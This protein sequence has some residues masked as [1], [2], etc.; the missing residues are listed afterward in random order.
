[1]IV[2]QA[3]R[4]LQDQ[5]KVKYAQKFKPNWQEDDQFKKWMKPGK[6]VHHAFCRVCNKQISV[7]ATGRLALVRHQDRD[8]H[9]KLSKSTKAQPS[10]TDMTLIKNWTS[11]KT[12]LKNADAHLAAFISEHNLPYNLMEHLPALLPKLC[13]DSDIAKKIQCSRTKCSS[14]VKNVLGKKNE[15]EICEILKSV[16]FSLVIDESTD[17]TCTKHLCLVVRYGFNK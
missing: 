10:I 6:D 14:L 5:K 12:A 2:I 4:V 11:Q 9:I 8:S 16:K 3:M 17:R 13:P 1:M 15:E 7:T